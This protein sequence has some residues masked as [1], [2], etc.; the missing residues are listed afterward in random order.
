M[1]RAI[2]MGRLTKDVELR[3]SKSEE[4]VA[5]AHFT[6]AINRHYNR[7]EVDFINCVAFGKTGEFINS[8]FKKGAMIAVE[9]NIQ[10]NS[11]E[12]EQTGRKRYKTEVIVTQAHF[13]GSKNEVG[14]SVP[15]DEHYENMAT[16]YS[17]PKSQEPTDNTTEVEDDDL[18][19]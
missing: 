16:N 13:T 8:Y 12:D 15:P 1:N 9:G 4:P 5:I 3:Y 17:Q 14:G 7:D 2:L 11:W 10:V 6:V 19:F 18:P